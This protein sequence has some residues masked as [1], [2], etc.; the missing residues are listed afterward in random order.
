MSGEAARCPKCGEAVTIPVA[1]SAA[2]A[3]AGCVFMAQEEL[4]RY[5][6]E[7]DAAISEMNVIPFI[8]I[9][10][11]LLIIVLVTASFSVKLMAFDHPLAFKKDASGNALL[12][13]KGNFIPTPTEYMDM[14]DKQGNLLVSTVAVK[15]KGLVTLNG[16][17]VPMSEL[18]KA[19]LALKSG[20]GYP[21]FHF[22]VARNVESQYVVMAA[23]QICEAGNVK[24]V[25]SIEGQ[26]LAQKTAPNQAKGEASA[27][28]GK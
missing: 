10:L 6:K 27:G 3:S 18:G 5:R 8:D 26:P 28:T 15:E 25:Y 1:N 11:V 13:D 21:P 9:C 2:P 22:V 24:I 4:E 19:A 20:G 23:D 16:R 7:G 17:A 12:D 14:Q